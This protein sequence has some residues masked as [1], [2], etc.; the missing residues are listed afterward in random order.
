MQ[1]VKAFGF[2]STY[3]WVALMMWKAPR[4]FSKNHKITVLRDAYSMWI[5]IFKNRSATMKWVYEFGDEFVQSLRLLR[6]AKWLILW[7][8][9]ISKLRFTWNLFVS[10]A[11]FSFSTQL[12]QVEFQWTNR[13][14]QIYYF[15]YKTLNWKNENKARW[16]EQNGF[17]QKNVYDFWLNY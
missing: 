6:C 5:Y 17:K 4:N 15:T 13:R 11:N 16:I 14:Y 10:R 8:F 1:S 12:I 3:R 7:F 9:S 2:Y